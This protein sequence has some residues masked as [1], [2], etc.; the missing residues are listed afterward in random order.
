MKPYHRKVQTPAGYKATAANRLDIYEA[1]I[2]I[3][4]V[5]PGSFSSSE[6]IRFKDV[7]SAGR[8][9]QVRK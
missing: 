6:V 7:A 8:Q 9:G 2:A 4:A 1:G 5:Q 3:G